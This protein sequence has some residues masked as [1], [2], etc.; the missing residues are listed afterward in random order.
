MSPK[1]MGPEVAAPQ[2]LAYTIPEA[3][4]VSGL[5]RD[6]FYRWHHDGTIT[7]RKSGSRTLI[8]A[9]EL[10]HVLEHLPTL[11]RHAA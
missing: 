3:V 11:G 9:A 8:L 7:M 4:K 10:E 5:S 1:G 2:K 6:T